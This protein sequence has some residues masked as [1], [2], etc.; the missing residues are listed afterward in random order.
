MG[1]GTN[2]EV[3]YQRSL[4]LTRHGEERSD[5]AIQDVPKEEGLDCFARN[6]GMRRRRRPK[7][8]VLHAADGG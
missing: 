8:V 5:E 4:T 6:D 3:L 7:T 1:P 2:L